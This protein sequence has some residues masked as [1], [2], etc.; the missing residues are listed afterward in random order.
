MKSKT[1]FILF[2]LLALTGLLLAACQP[3]QVEVVRTVVVTE[4]ITEEGETIVVT[5]VV[6]V[7]V[8]VE[9]EAPP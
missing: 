4:T 9:P 8:T 6:E 7:P 2:G 1:L 5:E 3:Q